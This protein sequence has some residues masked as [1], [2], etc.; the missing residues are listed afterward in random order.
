[1]FARFVGLWIEAS[2]VVRCP[3][4]YVE[5]ASMSDP[6]V[7]AAIITAAGVIIA[8]VLGRRRGRSGGDGSD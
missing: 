1:M 7:L 8:A 4:P 6:T 3:W 2:E 5:N